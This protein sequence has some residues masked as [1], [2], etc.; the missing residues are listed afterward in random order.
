MKIILSQLYRK[1]YI[2]NSLSWNKDLKALE[3]SYNNR[4]TDSLLGMSP[5]EILSS[6]KNI[7][8]MKKHYAKKIIENEVKYGR[9][10]MKET[11]IRLGDVV[12]FKKESNSAFTKSYQPKFSEKTATVTRISEGQAP[13][14]YYL[15]DPAPSR[16]FYEPELSLTLP[17]NHQKRTSDLFIDGQKKVSGRTLRSGKRSGQETLFLL[18]SRKNPGQ[19][20][21]ISE[22]EKNRLIS[23]GLLHI[24]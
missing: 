14:M 19:N 8:L 16:G 7:K 23:K 21:Y 20:K 4:R 17:S 15:S 24:D 11:D 2:D 9:K 3:N 13:R 18:K 12:R 1:L 10:K 5:N 22:T 6:E